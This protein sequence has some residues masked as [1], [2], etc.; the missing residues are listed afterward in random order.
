L[1]LNRALRIWKVFEYYEEYWQVMMSY[2]GERL[3]TYISK[4][5]KKRMRDLKQ[6]REEKIILHFFFNLGVPLLIIAILAFM[7]PWI[8]AIAPVYEA[9]ICWD[10][11]QIAPINTDASC[12]LKLTNNMVFIIFSWLEI[13]GFIAI[14]WMIRNI[15]NEINIKREI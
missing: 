1:F 2:T 3:S 14:F 8:Y 7:V 6:W 5:E 10:Y 9:N 4:E 12:S 11:F 15:R 13:L